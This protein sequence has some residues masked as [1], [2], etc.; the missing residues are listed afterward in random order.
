[1]NGSIRA[2]H[3]DRLFYFGNNILLLFF[4]VIT[5]YPVLYLFSSSISSPE[6]VATGQVVLFPVGFS[7]RGFQMVL[8]NRD[9]VTGYLNS[10]IY[11]IV[12][13][14]LNVAITLITAFVLSRRELVGRG[15]ISFFFAFTMWFSG[16]LIP[17][18]LLMQS[19][20]ILNTRWVMWLPGLLGVWNVII[21][22]TYIS[23]NIPE[24]L[25]ESVSIDGCGY[26]RFF[27]HIVF[28]LSGAIVAVMA[29]FYGIGHWNAYF[30]AFIYLTDK[31]L[32]PLQIVLRNILIQNAIESDMII[33]TNTSMAN[34][35]L[36]ELLKYALIIAA[37]LPLWVIY[38]F[39]QRFFVRGVMIGSIKG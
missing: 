4:F 17:S 32:F 35:G 20:G 26:Y 39:V 5:F 8:Q 23:G 10:F 21:C 24:E 18:Y 15:V 12:G 11:T 37:C 30:N 34:V 28:P 36:V 22:R 1:M 31:D 13:T 2:T 25:F 7:T 14:L 9:I 3:E 19:L 27:I 38:P 6:A 29:L 16:G 33:D